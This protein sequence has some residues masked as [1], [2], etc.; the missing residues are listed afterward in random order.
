VTRFL[1]QVATPRLG[2][3]NMYVLACDAC[4]LRFAPVGQLKPTVRLA[5]DSGWTSLDVP[6]TSTTLHYCSGCSE[7]R[8]PTTKLRR[9]R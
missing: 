7:M 5:E 6:H 2:W 4:G 1:T 8:R 9:K 3:R